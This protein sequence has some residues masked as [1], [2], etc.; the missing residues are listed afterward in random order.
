MLVCAIVWN[1]EYT[2]YYSL[3]KQKWQN[4]KLG[5]CQAINI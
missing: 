1:V 4:I 2:Q 3:S 5:I